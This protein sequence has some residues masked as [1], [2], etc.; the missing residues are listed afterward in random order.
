[1]LAHATIHWKL[2][3]INSKEKSVTRKL[4]FLNFA[5]IIFL[6]SIISLERPLSNGIGSAVKAHFT[7]PHWLTENNFLYDKYI[8]SEELPWQPNHWLVWLD[9]RGLM[10]YICHIHY[11][12][13]IQTLCGFQFAAK[14]LGIRQVGILCIKHWAK[15]VMWI[16]SFNS[17]SS[18][19][20]VTSTLWGNGGTEGW[21]NLT[22]VT[23]LVSGRVWIWIQAISIKWLCNLNQHAMQ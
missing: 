16:N 23:Q 19:L 15:H 4:L 2:H 12:T 18:L 5:K 3:S 13:A 1:M 7:T 8:P 10:N 20:C 6:G 14:M 17:H 21:R 11:T 22:K 9:Y